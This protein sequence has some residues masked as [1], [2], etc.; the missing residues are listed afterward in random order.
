VTI[1][2]TDLSAA[3]VLPTVTFGTAA[4]TA[5]S[6]PSS[7]SCTVVT[8]AHAGGTVDLMVSAAGGSS[9]SAGAFGFVPPPVPGGGQ[10]GVAGTAFAWGGGPFGTQGAAGAQAS[11]L[12]VLPSG[13]KVTASAAGDDFE[14]A[15]TDTGQVLAWGIGTSGQ[16]GNGAT[17]S[18]S[19]PVQV[20]LPSQVHVTA[21]AAGDNFGLALTSTGSVYAW[22]DNS[23]GELGAGSALA[24]SSTPLAVG[25][26]PNVSIASIAAGRTHALAL[27]T[28]G[29][30]Y[31]WGDNSTGELAG[32][33][34]AASSP[35]PVLIPVHAGRVITAVA[36]GNGFNV[37]LDSTG[38]AW[39]W[40]LNSAGQT[41]GN[42]FATIPSPVY[43]PG[44][45]IVTEVSAGDRFGLALTTSGQVYSWG[46]N[47]VGQLGDGIAG[48][49][50]RPV[51]V[52]LPA[53]SA[54]SGIAAGN[55]AALALTSTGQVLAWGDNSV[56]QAGNGGTAGPLFSPGPVAFPA[57]TIV[58]SVASGT[59]S[60]LSLAIASTVAPAVTAVSPNSGPVAGGTTV[61]VSGTGFTGA[62][63]VK[64]GTVAATSF[65]VVSDTR[66]TAVT[67]AQAAAVHGILVTTPGGT[68]AN[69]AADY[70]TYRAAP[71]VTSI[72]PT[73]GPVAGGTSVT[74]TGSGFTG[75]TAVK[76]GTVV[77]TSFTVVSDTQ[78][79]AVS[80]AQAAAVHG[81]LVTTPGGTS[82]N[83]A[84][85]Y[86]TYT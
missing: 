84:A 86:F 44:A 79:T 62:T 21:I 18:T 33:S 29:S 82:A 46:A 67:P 34:S 8:P 10:A 42:S 54:V 14:L 71:T 68:S 49:S 72:T 4:G 31:G 61:T 27:S 53:G 69:S 22:G 85:G 41:A 19:A 26:P 39:A 81:I 16:L 77:A 28:T 1:T 3:G 17:T 65:T 75:T 24:F 47:N 45:P 60:N 25:F 76:F 38:L 48:N 58:T 36:A 83:S 74:V 9:T 78:I 52:S 56:G 13:T 57:G 59:A 51:P 20:R 15:L 32:G 80:P 64:F 6:C 5:V 66:I 50:P 7:T 55:T 40:G 70:F 37:V 43:I 2:G 35:A 23:T 63:A 11:P 30:V 12:A 73:G